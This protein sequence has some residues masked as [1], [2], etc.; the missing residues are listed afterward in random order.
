LNNISQG[1][2]LLGQIAGKNK[3]L[4]AA[5]IIGESAVGIART[6]I[7]TSASNAATIAQGSSLAIPTGGASVVAA[8]KL[9]AANKI[10]AGISIAA[11]VAATAKALGGLK[12]GGSPPT[13]PSL[14]TSSS[15]RPSV[16]Q[17][18]A[19]DFNIVGQTGASQIADA[20]SG[21]N[22]QPFRAYVV[23]GD[24]TSGQSLERNIIEGASLGG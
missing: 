3:A 24:V 18:G 8:A 21:Q 16:P 4:Q 20:I 12:A 6:I 7:Q 23:A 2:A 15:T 13:P 5:A 22:Q 1:F 19:P 17:V 10:S 14:T 11:N 9:V